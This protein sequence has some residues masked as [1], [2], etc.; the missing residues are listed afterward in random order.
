MVVVL[1]LACTI[2]GCTEQALPPQQ[3]QVL[4]GRGIGDGYFQKPRAIAIDKQDNIYIVDMTARIQVFNKEG[5]YVRSWTTP[6]YDEGKPCGLSISNDGLLMVADT[7]CFRIL[8]YTPDGEL[9]EE[10]TIGGENGRGPGQFGFVTDC[11]QDSKDNYYVSEYGDFDRIQKFNPDGEFVTQ[12]GG[13]GEEPT[14]F[15]RPQGILMDENDHLWIADASNHR[16]QVFD[17]SQESPKLIKTFGQQGDGPGQLRYPYDLFFAPDGNLFVCEFG[18]HRI[19]KFTLDGES[20]GMFGEPGR[21]IGQFHQP[22]AACQT[23]EGLIHVLDSYNHRVQSF[24]WPVPK[25]KETN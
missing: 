25:A 21:A 11:V 5:E 15:L 1:A 2:I 4:G 23:S 24:L 3:I 9:V 8:F 12:W 18:N 22:W 13:H 20:L 10:R 17:V 16:I 19:Q 6:K 14:E 7:H